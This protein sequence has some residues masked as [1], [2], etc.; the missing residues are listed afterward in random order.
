[1]I[2]ARAKK[3]GLFNS[4]AAVLISDTEFFD[5]ER[6]MGATVEQL[7]PED[8]IETFEEFHAFELYGGYGIFEGIDQDARFDAIK[9]LL[10][11]VHQHRLSVVYGPVN[12]KLLAEK[13]YASANPT[14]I[15]FRICAQGIS[16]WMGENA[17][18]KRGNELALL[19]ADDTTDRKIKADLRQSF[20]HMRRQIRPPEHNPG[21]WYV[22]DDM[23]FGSSKDSVGIQ[24]ADLCGYF[25][26][27]HLESDVS[28]DGFYQIIADQ[29]CNSKVEPE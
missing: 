16:K 20:R 27:K 29:I 15:A 18:S 28:I 5:I 21:L 13:L 4:L 23:Y 26:A 11:M 8:R 22:H 2:L 14:D 7:L 10:S 19:I 9:R 6:D 17:T 12:T 3:R 24:L 1:M 25:I